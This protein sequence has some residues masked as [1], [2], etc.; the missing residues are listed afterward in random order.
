MD[1]LRPPRSRRTGCRPSDYSTNDPAVVRCRLRLHVPRVERGARHQH[2]VAHDRRPGVRAPADAA[3]SNALPGAHVQLAFD[4]RTDRDLERCV[5]DPLQV[6][7]RVGQLAESVRIR[8]ANA[9]WVDGA[10]L[11]LR[12][13]RERLEHHVAAVGRLGGRVDPRRHA[14]HILVVNGVCPVA[15]LAVALDAERRVVE[16]EAIGRGRIGGCGFR[17]RRS[18]RRYDR[19]PIIGARAGDGAYHVRCRTPQC[20]PGLPAQQGRGAGRHA[21]S[22][23][24][25]DGGDATRFPRRAIAELRRRAVGASSHSDGEE[26]GVGLEAYSPNS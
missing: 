7:R 6:R 12:A 20:D 14:A 3:A 22:V 1:D 8:D 5:L 2:A 21:P 11:I 25:Y 18:L 10:A 26:P 24:H 16:R 4:G 9:A 23:R 19:G 15:E 13:R 17:E